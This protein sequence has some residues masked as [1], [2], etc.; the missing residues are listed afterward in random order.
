MRK[1]F[2][3]LTVYM[4]VAPDV[5]DPPYCPDPKVKK[6]YES[7]TEEEINYIKER[8]FENAKI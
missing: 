6:E 8:W 7:L 3:R 4:V 1:K 2:H 5:F